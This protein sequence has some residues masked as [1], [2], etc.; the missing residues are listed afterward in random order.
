M[1]VVDPLGQARQA[2]WKWLHRRSSTWRGSP[3]TWDPFGQLAGQ[4]ALSDVRRYANAGDYWG[5]AATL[6][7]HVTEQFPARFFAGAFDPALPALVE[8]LFA[9]DRRSIVEEANALCQGRFDL[10][11]YRDVSFGDPP[12]WHLDPIARRRAP[13]V[14][15]S[16]FDPFD[17][18]VVSHRALVWELNRHQWLVT[19]GLA[20]R[21]TGDRSFADCFDRTIRDWVRMNPFGMGLNWSWTA[22]VARRLIAWC[23]AAALFLS[24][25]VMTADFFTLL[26]DVIRLHAVHIERFRS[27]R[28]TADQDAMIEGLGLL[29][30]GLLFPEF[31]RAA[32]WRR[33]GWRLFTAQLRRQAAEAA[34]LGEQSS[35]GQRVTLE[36]SLHGLILAERNGV[37]IDPGLL[38]LLQGSVDGLLRLRRPDGLMNRLGDR[39]QDWLLPLVRRDRNDWRGLFAVAAV[40]CRRPHYKWAAG[41]RRFELPWLLGSGGVTRFDELNAAPPSDA[42]PSALVERAGFAE[43]SSGRDRR[44]HQLLFDVGPSPL[45]PRPARRGARRDHLGIQCSAF[46][47]PIILDPEPELGD[48]RTWRMLFR[49][50]AHSTIVVDGVARAPFD[51]CSERA[52]RP[53]TCF[54]QWTSNERFQLA[55]AEHEGYRW[56]TQPVWHRRRVLFVKHAYWVLID[57]LEGTGRHRVDLCFHVASR[58]VDLD[59]ALLARVWTA[60][61]PGLAIQPLSSATLHTEIRQDSAA[62]GILVRRSQGPLTLVYRA[63]TDLPI[64]LVTHLFPL[65]DKDAPVPTVTPLFDEA[66]RLS[67]S[68]VDHPPATIMYSNRSVT[69]EAA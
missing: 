15:W 10:L 3:S 48:D 60:Q 36:A 28:R 47:E 25:P 27:L 8:T 19:L 57:D 64:R 61:G 32:G 35:D 26:L 9:T 52:G 37:A 6:K 41:E 20:Y 44:S 2:C 12:D 13:L 51:G 18:A 68:V 38:D 46:G 43:M 17:D 31:R 69:V 49:K 39:A 34:T 55:E 54:R 58:F 11:D 4:E 59:A 23:W 22:E 50:E 62:A 29:Y 24:A 42:P 53:R 56:L 1:D 30:A 63:E 66:G 67:G 21:L 16:L 45:L 33:R 40:L 7:R 14:H 65:A 5:A